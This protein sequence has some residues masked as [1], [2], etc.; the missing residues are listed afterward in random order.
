[1]FGTINK[2]DIADEGQSLAAFP[3]KLKMGVLSQAALACK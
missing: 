1:M 3:S 2:A